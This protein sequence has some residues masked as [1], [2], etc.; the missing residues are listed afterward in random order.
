M[1]NRSLV[2]FLS[3]LS[4]CAAAAFIAV[5]CSDQPRPKCTTGRG[6]F[7]ATYKPVAVA[8]AGC[9]LTGEKIGVEAYNP[10]LPDNSNADL[11]KGSIAI[12][13]G[14]MAAAITA[15][16]GVA[17]TTHDPNSIGN[18]STSEP[19]GDNFCDV[20]TLSAGGFRSR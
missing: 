5:S 16:G 6:Q 1:N 17:E 9:S 2:L 20:P 12:K 19:G 15:H 14:K 18:F 13:G 7:A 3:G 10:A 4:A 11:N 8:D